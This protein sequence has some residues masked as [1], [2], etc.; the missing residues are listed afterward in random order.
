MGRLET[1]TL[2]VVL[3]ARR[4]GATLVNEPESGDEKQHTCLKLRSYYVERESKHSD[5]TRPVGYSTC[6]PW[7]RFD[8]KRTSNL[9]MK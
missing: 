1:W 9:E 5:V 2:L 4:F 7:P 8:V 3:I 6:T